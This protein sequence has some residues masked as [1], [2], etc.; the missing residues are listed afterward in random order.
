MLSKSRDLDIKHQQTRRPPRE[1]AVVVKYIM[2]AAF[3]FSIK[4]FLFLKSGNKSSE[5]VPEPQV[6]AY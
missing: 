6:A 5:F 2:I 1:S 3:V 4:A